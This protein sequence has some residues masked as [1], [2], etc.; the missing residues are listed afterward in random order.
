MPETGAG[1]PARLALLPLRALLVLLLWLLLLQ[2]FALMEAPEL[3]WTRSSIGPPREATMSP[4]KTWVARLPVLGKLIVVMAMVTTK[5][6]GMTHTWLLGA[7][8]WRPKEKG[9][10][11][12]VVQLHCSFHCCGRARTWVPQV[13]DV[14]VTGLGCDLQS[15]VRSTQ[16]HPMA[17]AARD[18]ACL[19]AL[20]LK[21]NA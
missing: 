1:W 3:L 15:A 9:L 17:I 14:V 8:H 4:L 2:E 21:A 12:V 7:M 10:K 19:A 11:L 16:R 20:A 6:E 13:V 5:A 18:G